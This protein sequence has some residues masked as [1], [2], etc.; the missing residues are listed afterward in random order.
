MSFDDFDPKTISSMYMEKGNGSLGL[1]GSASNLTKLQCS[2]PS[3]SEIL[4][5]FNWTFHERDRDVEHYRKATWE[6]L[7]SHKQWTR[8]LH[9]SWCILLG[10]LWVKTLAP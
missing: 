10:N 5:E 7:L 6:G 4:G 2:K 1:I 3:I 8:I 9:N